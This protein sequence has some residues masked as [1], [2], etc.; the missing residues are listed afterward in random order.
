[1]RKTVAQGDESCKIFSAG[2]G[3]KK[4]KFYLSFLIYININ[5]FKSTHKHKCYTYKKSII[6]LESRDSKAL[7]LKY[8]YFR[9]QY[10]LKLVFKNIPHQNNTFYHW[11]FNSIYS[12][13]YITWNV[14]ET[15]RTTNCTRIYK[16]ILRTRSEKIS[17]EYL[18]KNKELG[19]EKSHSNN[20]RIKFG[21][22][23]GI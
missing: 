8:L 13:Y 12:R 10:Q 22:R 11:Y 7:F 21:F 1:M 23:S 6:F 16:V 18:I 20:I 15:Q 17:L 3:L 14:T 5:G 2:K 4:D 9:I 19:H